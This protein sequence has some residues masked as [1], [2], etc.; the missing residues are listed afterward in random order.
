AGDLPVKDFYTACARAGLDYGPAFRGL[1]SLRI[2]TR[3]VLADY[4]LQLPSAAGH[5]AHPAALDAAFQSALALL[6]GFT[7]EP[8]PFLPI[9]VETVRCWEAMPETGRVHARARTASPREFTVDLTITDRQGNVALEV[10]GLCARR[11]NAGH[12]PIQR[13]TETLRAAPL[14][15]YPIP[16]SPLPAPAAAHAATAPELDALTATWHQYDY[17]RFRHHLGKV[18]GHLTAAAIS[19]ILPGSREFGIE[20]LLAAGA[21]PKHTSLLR[22][23]L[24]VAHKYGPMKAATTGR[25]TLTG[26]P[27]PEQHFEQALREQSGATA[28]LTAYGVC[29]RHLAAVLLGTCDPLQ[30]LFSEAD[31]LAARVYD[32][33]LGSYGN[34]MAAQLLG[35][36]AQSWP[37][38]RPLRILEAGAGTGSLTS[39]LLPLLPPQNTHYVYTDVSPAY[40]PRAKA[41][42]SAYDFIDFR[43]FDLD[44]APDKQGFTP[45]SFDIVVAGNALHTARD[46]T[47]ALRHIAGLLADGGHLLA[48]ESHNHET[49]APVF[50]L[51][52]SFWT[53]TD[54]Q[55]RPDGPLLPR[56][57]WPDLLHQCGFTGTVQCG[58]S[59]E[60]A[61]SE[62]SVLLTARR[63]RTA[64]PIPHPAPSLDSQQAHTRSCLVIGS[65]GST[66]RAETVTDALRATFPGTVESIEDTVGPAAI[67]QRLTREPTPTD[68]LLL[69]GPGNT[70]E[71]TE[72]TEAALQHLTTLRTVSSALTTLSS[73]QP[74]PSRTLWIAA[75]SPMDQP[76]PQPARGPAAALWGAARS[77]ANEQPNLSL[78]RIALTL[79]RT[80]QDE[81]ALAEGLAR[82]IHTHTPDDEV[83]LTPQGRFTLHVQPL[84][85]A[86]RTSGA[87]GF[88]LALDDIGLH[89]ELSWQPTPVPVPGE[90]EV[91]IQVAA[92]GL[93]YRDVLVAVGK[94]PTITTERRLKAGGLGLECSGVISAVGPKVTHLSPGDRV[95]G[96][97]VGSLGSHAL[98]R[99]SLL[100]HIP[101]DMTFAQAATFPVTYL[102][103]HHSLRY[104]ARLA[105]GETVLV[106]GA[107]GG[108]GLAALQVARTAGAQVIATAGTPAKRDLLRLLGVQHVLDSRTLH[109]AEQ[110]KD[111]TGGQGVDV[112]LN[113][114]SGEALVRSLQLLKPCGRF[115]ELGKQ[116]F[117]ADNALP[118]APFLRNIAFHGVEVSYLLD[119]ASAL[120]KSHAA[121]ISK[122]VQAGEYRP[123]LHRTYPAHRIQ[124]AFND[125]QHSRHIGKVVVTFD[126]P[127][128]VKHD[129][130]PPR[131]DPEATYLITGGLSGFGA[132]TARHLADRGARHLTLLSRRG[133]DAPEAPRLLADLR[134]YGVHADARAVDVTDKAALRRV[135]ADIDAS[136][137]RLAGI[138]HAAM[139]WHDG[140]LSEQNDEC[141]RTVLAP[142][143][144]GALLLDE[145]TREIP[146]DFFVIYS[147]LSVLVGQLNLSSYAAANHALEA[148]VRDRRRQGLPAL[149]I[150][151]GVITDAGVVERSG[152]A[153][154]VAMGGFGSMLRATTAL[155]EMDRLLA[156][157]PDPVVTIA[158][159]DWA[160]V[161]H[162]LPNLS[163]PRTASLIPEYQSTEAADKLKSAL[164]KASPE[165]AHA[166]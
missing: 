145:L 51:L 38:N 6:P 85:P 67:A 44:S 156:G 90:G 60:P 48:A 11:F 141:I 129:P 132:A 53:A 113:S 153:D 108:V 160:R 76:E 28:T 103:A 157:Q 55:L 105:P 94:V 96:P 111:L 166:L 155:R 20:D 117:L 66:P 30:L 74:D 125:L 58:D 102:T 54:T 9:S 120:G 7:D 62:Q 163:A 13:L 64:A 107:A 2:G 130:Q 158:D 118:L 131:L 128:P 86:H 150:Q 82:E 29:G 122:A 89:Y 19:Q 34:T 148:L 40:F 17:A 15:G 61:R 1:T 35:H 100:T 143:M 161:H 70:T 49:M 136:G 152:R 12:P 151:W 63:P 69:T 115:L 42:F 18:V 71:A 57:A 50:G 78:R 41:R 165:E 43:I 27:R 99:A 5:W 23:L 45:A 37:R 39:V 72:A 36:L 154:Q 98:A 95:A 73:N 119:H 59:Q 21:D 140:P 65:P 88:I 3:E 47:T 109:F 149:A 92:A 56:D 144:T 104:L 14:P 10:L 164:A 133:P 123:L 52:D 26:T 33:D 121:A 110:V 80:A 31:S 32:S 83:V 135:L 138:I 93:N 139:A 75:S 91:V 159:P 22:I 87:D 24:D 106:H 142:K 147:S 146:L 134:D 4:A 79:P 81:K 137:H 116:D 84:P 46:L 114:L 97:A 68:V 162:W 126:K 8:A 25:W 77:L 124:D 16:R 112:V 101:A 127:V